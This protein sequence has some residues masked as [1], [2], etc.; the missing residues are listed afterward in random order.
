[1]MIAITTGF[2]SSE[3]I[4]PAGI[5][6]GQGDG[7]LIGLSNAIAGAG[8]VTYVRLMAEM[9]NYGN[10]YSAYNADG[11][12]RDAAHSTAA[13]KNAWKRVALIM[14]GGSLKHIDAVLARLGMPR[15]HAG[16]D[17]PQPKVAMLWVP[18]VAGRPDVSGNQPS[19]YWPGAN[20]VDWVGTDFYSQFPNFSGLNALYNA[21]PGFPFVFGEYALWGSDDPG[22]VDQLFGW[23]GSHPRTRM[24]VY[25]QGV[26]PNGPFRLAQYPNATRELRRMLGG[27]KFPA[28]AP[29]WAR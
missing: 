13:F 29:E 25:N 1:M 19:D 2:G 4:T 28:Y 21:Y 15:L 16:H 10:P 20:W 12:P 11:S 26:N 24:L 22:W 6:N 27:S 9:D 8:N 18:Q 23:V 5:A 17:L 7:W 3:A 14:R